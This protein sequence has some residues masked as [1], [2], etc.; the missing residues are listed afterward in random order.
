MGDVEGDMLEVLL[1]GL[2]D[3]GTYCFTTESES[4]LTSR[5]W[6]EYTR[7]GYNELLAM[8][9]SVPHHL[10]QSSYVHVHLDL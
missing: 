1:G 2:A 4:K 9:E 10:K 8:F 6:N 7:G 5:Y 3:P